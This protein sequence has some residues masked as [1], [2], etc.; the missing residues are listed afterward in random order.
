MCIKKNADSLMHAG[1]AGPP[2]PSS[3]AR[4]GGPSPSYPPSPQG[5]GGRGVGAIN[6]VWQLTCGST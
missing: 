5:G 4:A 2:K 1:A 3:E 6:H